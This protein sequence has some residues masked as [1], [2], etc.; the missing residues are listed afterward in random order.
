MNIAVP[1]I[2]K[3]YSYIPK[4]RAFDGV[5]QPTAK[6]NV[7]FSFCSNSI[8]KQEI[9]LQIN[10]E[11]KFF[12]DFLDANG[13][14]TK[15]E[16]EDIVKNHPMAL[17]KMREYCD[18]DY[19]G[20]TT[21]EGLAQVVLETDRLL[22][23]KYPDARIISIGT[24]PSPITEQLQYL[25]HEIIF[26]PVSG[27]RRYNPD[28]KMITECPNFKILTK[29]IKSKKINND[30]LN[31]V[32]DFTS[33]GQTLKNM[34]QFIK[35]ICKIKDKNIKAISI[36]NLL[37]SS[38]SY[39]HQIENQD[40]PIDDCLLDMQS[41]I[42]ERISNVPHFSVVYRKLVDDIDYINIDVTNKTE[43]QIFREFEDYSRPL[44]RAF[45]LCTMHEINKKRKIDKN[46][47]F[48]RKNY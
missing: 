10:K 32:L 2:N 42:I 18:R 41:S 34:K 29:Y 28:N 31:V 19:C 8:Q 43:Q 13:K 27:F 6:N 37:H 15:E 7:N 16:Y 12:V 17:M 38:Y 3:T 14:V 5:L 40:V 26:I 22:K 30:K 24:S 1:K 48:T 23:E 47:N 20:C 45:S 4:N 9:E 21:P 25:G 35:D 39:K 11:K 33:T 44:A 46:E 36:N